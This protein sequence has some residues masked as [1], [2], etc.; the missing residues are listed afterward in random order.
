L[1]RQDSPALQLRHAL[2]PRPHA[3]TDVPGWHS[4]LLSQQP[5]HEVASQA[6]FEPP[7][8][9][10]RV[11]INPPTTPRTNAMERRMAPAP[12]V[13]AAKA[14]KDALSCR[15][16]PQRATA[17]RRTIGA[18]R[19]GHDRI[20]LGHHANWGTRAAPDA[21]AG[22][23]GRLWAVVPFDENDGYF[24]P[25]PSN[26]PTKAPLLG[27]LKQAR[28]FVV[29]VVL[30]TQNPVDLDH[31]GLGNIGT[32]WVG[33]LQTDQD[34]Q[35]IRDALASAATAT[36]ATPAQLD[37]LIA[38]LEPRQFLLHSVHRAQ[39]SCTGRGVLGAPRSLLRGRGARAD[40]ADE[41]GGTCVR[42]AARLRSARARGLR[43][44]G[45]CPWRARPRHSRRTRHGARPHLRDGPEIEQLEHE[46]AAM[47][48]VD[49]QRYEEQLA[50]PRASD[51]QVLR[52]C[53]AYIVP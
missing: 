1:D 36:G 44:R 25:A 50:L 32:W 30:A 8:E 13:K 43:R 4:L 23:R 40:G 2:P 15:N 49:P 42:G 48:E 45:G 20:L 14:G 46:L 22:R 6:L 33:P 19:P 37:A 27:L 10:P 18:R 3:S 34:K 26:P 9:T 53:Y 35:R 51:V 24:P 11:N 52:L 31:R 21:A 47:K 39:P 28:A 29:S 5:V 38:T 16:P 17:P 41:A 12:Q 7:H